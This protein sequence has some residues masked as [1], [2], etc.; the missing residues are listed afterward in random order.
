MLAR[1]VRRIHEVD[2]IRKAV[3]VEKLTVVRL[4]ASPEVIAARL[5]GRDSGTQL[6]EHLAEA[7][8]FAADAE[9]AGIGQIVIST[10]DRTIESLALELLER[11]G[12]R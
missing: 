11:A 10:D 5:G 8:G 4:V 6:A 9:S 12:W 2:A 7:S 3:G 1:A